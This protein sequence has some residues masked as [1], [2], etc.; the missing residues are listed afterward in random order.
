MWLVPNYRCFASIL[1]DTRDEFVIIRAKQA[2]AKTVN[3]LQQKARILSF[4]M[5]DV[6][7]QGISPRG[8]TH[9][10]EKPPATDDASVPL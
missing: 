6:A 2:R 1:C 9:T 10:S 7:F 8:V 4:E 5:R 3:Q